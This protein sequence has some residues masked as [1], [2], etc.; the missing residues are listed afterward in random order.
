[1]L[2]SVVGYL[3]MNDVKFK[4]NQLLKNYSSV[5]IG[6]MADIIAFPNET[7]QLC[8]TIDFLKDAQISNKIFGRMTNVLPSDHSY[9]GVV[10]KTDGLSGLDI[11][12]NVINAEVGISLPLLS[13][14][15][16]NCGLS[17]LEELSGIPG[18]LG[19]AVYGNAGAFGREIAELVTTIICYDKIHRKNVIL[20]NNDCKFSYRTS[21]FK[22]NGL[23]PLKVTLSLTKSDSNN[24]KKRMDECREI[25]RLTQP[26]GVK[27]LGSTFKRVS[28]GTSAA[29]LIDSCGLKGYTLGGAK[30]SEKH[31]GFIINT[32]T[33]SAAD[34][35]GVMEYTKKIVKQKFDI[36]LEEE[37][38]IF[39]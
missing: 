5:S 1:M 29:K 37:I 6:G 25:R 14:K 26:V 3:K 38:E 31:A 10:V 32:G 30:V 17:G 19:G 16:L 7:K 2:E 18:S 13:I 12:D 9:H 21:Y 20:S 11:K 39:N 15:A 23:I 8:Q 27:S 34:Y 33:A 4:V 35:I 22:E 36:V 28:S 24:I